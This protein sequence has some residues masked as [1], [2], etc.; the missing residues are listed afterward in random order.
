MP[1]RPAPS[2]LAG[3]PLD[4][5]RNRT[6]KRVL[7][8]MARLLPQWDDSSLS[9]KDKCDIY[10]LAC[11]SLPSRYAQPGTI[12]LGRLPEKAVDDA[13]RAAYENVVQNPKK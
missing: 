6:E 1:R 12:I 8:S 5:I 3:L 2:A 13:V 9:D 10:A 11:N 4:Q 7:A